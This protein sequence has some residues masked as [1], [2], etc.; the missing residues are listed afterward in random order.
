M[1]IIEERTP[2]FRA[3]CD[4]CQRLSHT[5]SFTASEAQTA[6]IKAGWDCEGSVITCSECIAA[7]ARKKVNGE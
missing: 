1:P 6:L 2:R 4:S 5:L 3:Q 7:A